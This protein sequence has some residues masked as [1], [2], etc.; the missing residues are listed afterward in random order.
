MLHVES[1]TSLPIEGKMTQL[2]RCLEHMFG[3]PSEGLITVMCEDLV[4]GSL[5]FTTAGIYRVH[6]MA[7]VRDEERSWSLVVKVS[8][9]DSDD[10]KDD[11]QHHNYWRRE[12]LLLEA[13][14]LDKLPQMIRAPKCY[15]VEEQPDGTIWMWM[16]HVAEGKYPQTQKQLDNV[17]YQL[18]RFNGDYLMGRQ[19]LP[20]EPWICRRWLKSWT[21]GSRK[22]APNPHPYVNQLYKE[23]ERS[24]WAWF[25]GLERDEEQLLAALDRLPR[26]LAHQDLGQ[27]NILLVRDEHSAAERIVLIDWQ[28]M[29]ISGV[30]EDLAKLFGVHMSTGVIPMDRVGA[31][32]ESLFDAYIDGLRAAGWEGDAAL[33]RYGFCAATALRSVWE[34]PRYLAWAAQ[35]EENPQDEQLGERMDWLEQIIAIHM[36]MAAE[37]RIWLNI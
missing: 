12:A 37:A 13:G 19:E 2:S 20:N 34:V 32:R 28:F 26:V 11:E 25:Q 7:H 23:N 24:M 35:L 18:G 29:S 31:Y 4:S 22:Y 3:E 8:K 21:V 1:R 36:Q 9:P 6:G 5:N 17:A 10:D 33:A 16:E 15:L 30:G 27:K 14:L